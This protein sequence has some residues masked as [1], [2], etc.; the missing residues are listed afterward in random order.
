MCGNLDESAQPARWRRGGGCASA[1]LGT[2]TP[3][4]IPAL[5]S[6]GASVTPALCLYAKSTSVPNS[7][8]SP[9]TPTHVRTYTRQGSEMVGARW[10]RPQPCRG[11]A[12]L[13]GGTHG[14]PQGQFLLQTAKRSSKIPTHL[15]GQVSISE[16]VQE[17]PFPRGSLRFALLT[18]LLFAEEPWTRSLS[19]KA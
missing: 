10:L 1:G 2:Q 4:R 5:S 14:G 3:L 12:G 11:R 16:R 17:S 19:I 13:E 6:C 15:L 18:H 9:H 8:G 7:K